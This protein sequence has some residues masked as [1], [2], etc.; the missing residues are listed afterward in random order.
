MKVRFVNANVVAVGVGLGA[1]LRD[2]LAVHHDAARGNHF[3]RVAAAGNARLG[4]NL[5]QP[6]EMSF[7][8]WFGGILVFF[9]G[10]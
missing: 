2:H 3:F 1:K 5:L 10:L 9:G 8:T 7:G 6:F 4:E